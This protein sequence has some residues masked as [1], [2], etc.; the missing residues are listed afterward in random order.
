MSA[1]I[2]LMVSHT[3]YTFFPKTPRHISRRGSPQGRRLRKANTA[4]SRPR[5]GKL[6]ESVEEF[7]HDLAIC[8]GKVFP[9]AFKVTLND[10]L[11]LVIRCPF[12]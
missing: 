3:S 9:T 5:I 8:G 12:S 4:V 10:L 6:P 11:H 7:L 1:I 2:L